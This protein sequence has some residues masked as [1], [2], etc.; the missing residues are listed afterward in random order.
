MTWHDIPWGVERKIRTIFVANTFTYG[1]TRFLIRVLEDQN[2][3]H[4]NPQ[5]IRQ[6]ASYILVFLYSKTISLT[7]GWSLTYL[8]RAS[9][10]RDDCFQSRVWYCLSPLCRYIT[11]TKWKYK[12][13]YSTVESSLDQ[14][15]SWLT[16]RSEGVKSF[17]FPELFLPCGETASCVTYRLAAS[18]KQ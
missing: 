6:L 5:S 8:L 3:G 13:R 7:K 10:A 11:G 12:K 4:F 9:Q 1:H 16:P 14:R 2:L 18:L 17:S 15:E